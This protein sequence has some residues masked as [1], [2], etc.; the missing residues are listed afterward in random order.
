[1][2]AILQRQG[3][4]ERKAGVFAEIA[5]RYAGV[6]YRKCVEVE[7]K[8]DGHGLSAHYRQRCCWSASSSSSP[9]AC[10]VLKRKVSVAINDRIPQEVSPF[11]NSAYVQIQFGSTAPARRDS[12]NSQADAHPQHSQPAR[13]RGRSAMSGLPERVAPAVPETPAVASMTIARIS[14]TCAERQTEAKPQ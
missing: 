14:P 11:V 3:L 8:P 4:S 10:P 6:E 9:R 1:M 12:S 13:R 2:R 7:V 5:S